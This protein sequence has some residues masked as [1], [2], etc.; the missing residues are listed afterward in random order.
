MLQKHVFI[1]WKE[2][3]STL[4]STVFYLSFSTYRQGLCC[5]DGP[6]LHQEKG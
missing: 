2:V 1:Y 4:L 3:V 5:A 6:T